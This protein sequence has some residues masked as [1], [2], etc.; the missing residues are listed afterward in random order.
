MPRAK[1]KTVTTAEKEKK[2]KRPTRR[3]LKEEMVG[4]TEEQI[5]TIRAE[6]Q[7]ESRKDFLK[8]VNNYNCANTITL[9]GIRLNKKTEP[10]LVNIYKAIPN[11]G[12]WIRQCLTQYA[13][14][15]PEVIRLYEQSLKDGI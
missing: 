10:D 7:E 3:L 5:D 14:E 6:R 9:G 2:E 12:D 4:L 1:K 8:Y 11:K 13:K 15:H